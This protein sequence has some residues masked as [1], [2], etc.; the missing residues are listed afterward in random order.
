MFPRPNKKIENSFKLVKKDIDLIKSRLDDQNKLL[1]EL[2]EEIET[3]KRLNVYKR[4]NTSPKRL[5]VFKQETQTFKQ[6]GSIEVSDLTPSESLILKLFYD[7]DNTPLTYNDI[8]K[9]L[10]KSSAVIR[11]QINQ[12]KS[13]SNILM[14]ERGMD[15]KKRYKINPNLEVKKILEVSK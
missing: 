9:E 8:A 15:K 6:K 14:E 2:R 11:C 4:L 10:N 7:N 3:F 1:I 5:N 13:K 12:L